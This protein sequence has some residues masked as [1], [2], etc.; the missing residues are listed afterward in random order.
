[1]V[2]RMRYLIGTRGSKLAL[3]QTNLVIE[4]LTQAYPKDEFLPVV[5]KTT[6]DI[7][8]N[9]QLDQI[10]SKGIFVKE[11]EEELFRRKNSDGGS[12]AK[13]YARGACGGAYVCKSVA[14]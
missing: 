9:R 7:V 2:I 10:G 11:I 3:V 4:K 5:I 13:R 6:G 14:S 12:F 8:K 1:M